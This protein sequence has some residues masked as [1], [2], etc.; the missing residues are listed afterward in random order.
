MATKLDKDLVRET[1]II[2]DG[3]EIIL[4]ITAEQTL[5]MKLKG[6]KSG[7]VNIGIGELYSQL[8]GVPIEGLPV[9]SNVDVVIEEE[10]PVYE[11]KKHKSVD[12]S[13]LISLHDL[14]HRCN[15]KGFDYDMTAKFDT[16]LNELLDERKK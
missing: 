9:E 12:D 6:M 4:T 8:K 1:T 16:V 13:T 15:V 10:E 7:F 3:R 14:R 11:H 5:S 2:V